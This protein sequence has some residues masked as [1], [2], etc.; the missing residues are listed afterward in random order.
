M[1]VPGPRPSGGNSPSW[2]DDRGVS[3]TVSYVLTIAIAV[4]LVGGI[5]LTAGQ[6]VKTQRESA[7]RDAATVTGDETA[8]AVMAVDRLVRASNETNET[9]VTTAL[10]LPETL[11]DQPYTVSLNASGG[12]GIVVVEADSPGVVVRTPLA[13]ETPVRNATVAGGDVR[14]VYRRS[15][16]KLTLEGGDG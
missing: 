13:V 12:E 7:I 10:A 6:T 3:F 11:A 1:T 2:R 4:L 16:G 9:N 5:I 8:A 14:V 15:T